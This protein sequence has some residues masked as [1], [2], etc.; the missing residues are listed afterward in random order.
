MW[1][2]WWTKWHWG[3]FS[4]STSVSPANSH[5]TDCSTFIIYN[6]GL[7]HKP[8]CGRRTKWA[9]S[10]HSKKLK[11]KKKK[12]H[13][14]PIAPRNLETEGVVM[15]CLVRTT[16]HCKGQSMRPCWPSGLPWIRLHDESSIRSS[17]SIFLYEG[18]VHSHSPFR[19]VSLQT[20]FHE[21]S[22]E[23][24]AAVGHSNI[25]TPCSDHNRTDAGKRWKL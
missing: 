6:P 21:T 11:K 19:L 16:A 7:V 1:G 2:L 25:L 18:S 13:L 5:S 12:S 20:D 24:Y 15:C 10:P 17:Q 23:H 3:R 14:L 22:H 8:I 4:L 9:V